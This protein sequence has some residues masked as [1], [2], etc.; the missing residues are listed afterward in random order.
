MLDS[1]YQE[2]LNDRVHGFKRGRPAKHGVELHVQIQPDTKHLI[3][4]LRKE[5]GISQGEFID[6]ICFY[7]AKKAEP[8]PIK[9]N[10]SLETTISELFEAMQ[11]QKSLVLPKHKLQKAIG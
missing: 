2:L 8:L 11:T 3:D 5:I 10:L 7:Y 1:A 9:T 6:L 4:K